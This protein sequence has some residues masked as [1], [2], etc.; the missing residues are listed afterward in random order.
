MCRCVCFPLVWSACSVFSISLCVF[1]FHDGALVFP[2]LRRCPWS[3]GLP[4][5]FFLLTM[6]VL[7]FV[8]N[9]GSLSVSPRMVCIHSLTRLGPGSLW[10]PNRF[11]Y[12][13]SAAYSCTCLRTQVSSMLIEE[14][15][16]KMRSKWEQGTGG[17]SGK[18][19]AWEPE[20]HEAQKRNPWV[21]KATTMAGLSGE[22]LAH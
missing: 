4:L 5:P 7:V 1:C 16:G 14:E 6:S 18:A 10:A 3:F 15:R 12:V 20:W 13:F 9:S 11:L 19:G 2:A 8:L 22:M 21:T 17:A